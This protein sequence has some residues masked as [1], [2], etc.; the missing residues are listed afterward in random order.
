[1]AFGAGADWRVEPDLATGLGQFHIV[2]QQ[3]DGRELGPA[4]I[5]QRFQRGDA[6][7]FLEQR[8]AG[9]VGGAAGRPEGDRRGGEGARIGDSWLVEIAFRDEQF[10]QRIGHEAVG[11]RLSRQGGHV[12]SASRHITDS[13][14][15]FGPAG[16]KR[17]GGEGLVL[18][19]RQQGVFGQRARCHDAHDIPVHDRLRAA[20]LRFG[21]GFGLLA[22][23]DPAPG[24]DQ[25]RQIALGGMVGHPS[26]RD[27]PALIFA[28]RGQRDVE[29]SGGLHGIFEKQ[30]VEIPHPEEQQGIGMPRLDRQVLRHER[31]GR[32][33]GFRGS[34]SV[35]HGRGRYRQ[36]ERFAK[37]RTSLR[38]TK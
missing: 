6:E 7:G 17:D 33:R 29:H 19:C 22:H 35:G 32:R 14:R 8:F 34:S 27:R 20:L 21:G 36:Q 23:R 25:A 30:L 1:M 28:P 3:A 12:K 15:C 31:A 11:E 18:A 2:E 10:R 4:E 37:P 24:L 26:H 16:A 5:A 38:A 9:F 13:N